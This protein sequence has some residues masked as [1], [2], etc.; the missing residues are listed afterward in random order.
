MLLGCT[1][2]EEKPAPGPAPAAPQAADQPGT[3]QVTPTPQT[4][5]KNVSGQVVMDGAKFG[6]TPVSKD[7]VKF[8]DTPVNNKDGTKPGSTATQTMPGFGDAKAK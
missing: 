4:S 7:G 8:G 1:S 3:R 6:N 2:S 5:V